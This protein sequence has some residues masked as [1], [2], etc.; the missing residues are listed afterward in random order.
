MVGDANLRV[1]P[2]SEQ[3]PQNEAQV[4]V[5]ALQCHLEHPVIP[6]AARD[7]VCEPCGQHEVR[8][9]DPS[10]RSCHYPNLFR[11]TIEGLN[12]Q[13]AQRFPSRYGE[14]RGHNFFGTKIWVMTSASLR[15]TL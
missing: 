9:A 11:T 7:L 3:P 6:S 5:G 15:M 12:A 13:H 1:P 10:L 4:E 8:R 2:G 14:L